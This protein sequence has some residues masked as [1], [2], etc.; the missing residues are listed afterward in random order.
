MKKKIEK[1]MTLKGQY[2]E[3]VLAVIQ[4]KVGTPVSNSS[5]AEVC[6]QSKQDFDV[7]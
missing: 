7:P 1:N 3:K 6:A 4:K 2:L 5:W